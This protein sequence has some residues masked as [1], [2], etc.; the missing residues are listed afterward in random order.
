MNCLV[1]GHPLTLH[2]TAGTCSR[3]TRWPGMED[4]QCPLIARVRAACSEECG[5]DH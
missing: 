4:C 1:C 2:T 3:F 5:Y